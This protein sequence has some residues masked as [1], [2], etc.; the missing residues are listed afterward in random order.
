MIN[1]EEHGLLPSQIW[2]FANLCELP[3]N[4]YA[5]DFGG[6]D[7]IFL[8]NYAIIESTKLVKEKRGEVYS[9]ISYLAEL[10][11]EKIVDKRVTK[12]RFYLA[13]VESFHQPL[14]VVPDLDGPANRYIVFKERSMW[15]D[16]FA[17]WLARDYE[18]FPDFED[19]LDEEEF[20]NG[21]ESGDY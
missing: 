5:V 18:K 7:T 17:K 6:I 20:L 1:W 16:D 15:K 13:H 10:E 2:G 8:G 3:T 9:E 12:L 19:D 11:V 4:G 14:F 21:E